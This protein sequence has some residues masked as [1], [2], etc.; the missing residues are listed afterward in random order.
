MQNI[1][2][3]LREYFVFQKKTT[4]QS[5]QKNNTQFDLLSIDYCHSAFHYHIRIT[6]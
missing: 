5:T 2:K 3:E 4:E 6:R 1:R